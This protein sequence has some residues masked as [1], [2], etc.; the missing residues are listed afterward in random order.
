MWNENNMSNLN[1]SA[2]KNV[3]VSLVM[4]LLFAFNGCEHEQSIFDPR[5]TLKMD[6][7]RIANSPIDPV[8]VLD[9]CNLNN[10]FDYWGEVFYL[11]ISK[12]FLERGK[13][14]LIKEDLNLLLVDYIPE[15]F[16]TI[17][18][19]D[20][21]LSVISEVLGEFLSVFINKNVYEAIPISL[22]MEDYL[23]HTKFIN[24]GDRACLLKMI[25]VLRFSTYLSVV[26]QSK[27]D[28]DYEACWIGK[29]RGVENAG[30]FEKMSCIYSWPVCFGALAADCL[31]E[32]YF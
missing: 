1:S 8:A 30:F 14:G 28:C 27:S 6:L 32:V 29:L 4:F 11:G 9:P 26:Y 15:D 13:S 2:M 3:V 22:K 21:D 19:T 25:S 12:M 20:V 23:L 31:I 17:D 24:E 5:A 16:M 7:Q 18:T 10:N